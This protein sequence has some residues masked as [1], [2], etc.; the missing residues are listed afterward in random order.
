MDYNFQVDWISKWAK[1][2]PNKFFLR[3]YN[4]S[5]EWNFKEFNNAANHLADYL[6]SKVG[7]KK[8]D[9]LAVYSS[10]NA[11][12]VLLFSA[13]VK[14]GIILVPLNF[15]LAPRE[16]DQ[17][18]DDADPK[19]L[20]YEEEY[21]ENFN[22]LKSVQESQVKLKISDISKF[23]ERKDETVADYVDSSIG[24]NDSVM[25]LY[26]S[27]TTGKSKGALITHKMLF[28]NAVNTSL[29]LDLN[30]SDHTQSF[31]PFFHTGGWNVLFTPFLHCGASH[32]LLTKFDAELILELMQN[33]KATIL[34]GVPTMLQMMSD[35]GKFNKVDLSSVRYAIVGGA[36]M[37]IPLIEKW[38]SKG[39]YIRQ[40]YGLTEVGPN[41]FS[42]HHD[43]AVKKKGSI[44]FPNFYFEVKLM[45]E[46]NEECGINE[47][48]ELW[49][50]SPVVTP[51]Y[52]RNE[53]A[54][55]N[56]I[57]D[58]WFHTGDM[59]RYDEDG[60]FY[61]VDRKKNMYISGGENVYPAEVEKYLYTNPKIK[62][63]AVIG[64]ADEKWGE[65]GKAFIVLKENENSTESEFYEYCLGNLAKY[66]I[67]KYYQIMDELPRNEAGKIDKKVLLELHNKSINLTK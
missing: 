55:T 54:T 17:L 40:G 66:K 6:I 26:T 56:S 12:Y 48:G 51:G 41:V 31:A 22:R 39:V 34:F 7:L 10:N 23:F 65:V 28:W 13:C 18:I 62:E 37:P 1:Y 43:D 38:H 45:N 60:Y 3:E 27:G 16:L 9:R 24:E 8:K 21:E 64:V 32:T 36:P 5:R 67:P 29:R 35:S 46:K 11:E 61:V 63:A 33:E 2:T 53:E 47:V 50:K 58:G 52:W 57:T 25:I 15:R 20:V 14:T 59:M 49:I 42:L 44:G 4:S 30:S 19:V